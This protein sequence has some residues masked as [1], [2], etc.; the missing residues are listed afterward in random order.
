MSVQRNLNIINKLKKNVD[1][2][3]EKI[4]EINYKFEGVIQNIDG[5]WYKCVKCTTKKI[6][7]KDD[8]VISYLTLESVEGK[9][10]EEKLSK[11]REQEGITLLNIPA[12]IY[13]LNEEYK[14]I[15]GIFPLQKGE[16]FSKF[17]KDELELEEDYILYP[18]CFDEKINFDEEYQEWDFYIYKWL[19]IVREETNY[20]YNE[21]YYALTDLNNMNKIQ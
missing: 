3:D 8:E 5:I 12:F 16:Q 4:K 14:D 17:L 21:C 11:E 10:L 15:V 19:I 6:E 7:K 2:T 1:I 20:G 13:N 18:E 9:E